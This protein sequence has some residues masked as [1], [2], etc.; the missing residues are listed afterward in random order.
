MRKKIYILGLVI[1]IVLGLFFQA[2]FGDYYSTPEEALKHHNEFNDTSMKSIVDTVWIDDNRPIIFYVS[3]SDNF[4]AMEFDKKE[5]LDRTGWKSGTIK[6][7]DKKTIDPN[8]L[9]PSMMVSGTENSGK[10]AEVV[11]GIT[12]SPEANTI[13]ENRQVPTFKN[14]E[15]EGQD[16][17]LWY[18]IRK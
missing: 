3:N 6:I 16:Y 10:E 1:I 17:V 11:Y 5:I 2:K 8:I 14:F 12:K 13:R 18:V 9:I 7:I 15:I 4:C